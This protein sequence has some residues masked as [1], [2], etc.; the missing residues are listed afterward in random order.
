MDCSPLGSSVHA[1]LQAR[2]LEWVAIS[3]SRGSSPPR[4]KFDRLLKTIKSGKAVLNNDKVNARTWKSDWIK[5]SDIVE[6]KAIVNYELGYRKICKIKHVKAK[7]N[8]LMRK[9][10]AHRG[11]N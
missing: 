9:Y 6:E 5:N 10:K 7:G 2:V 8:K 3:F 1:I 4:G 11:Y